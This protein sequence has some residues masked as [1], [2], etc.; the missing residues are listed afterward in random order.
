VRELTAHEI[1]AFQ[2]FFRL[3]RR[4]LYVFQILVTNCLFW[5]SKSA[6]RDSAI[7]SA[8]VDL[9][10]SIANREVTFFNGT[11]AISFL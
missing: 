1:M 3:F 5:K 2:T 6:H 11:V 9:I 4:P 10:R 7:G 8:V